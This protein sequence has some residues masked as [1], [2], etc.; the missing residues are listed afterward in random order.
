M[1]AR[2]D[3]VHRDDNAD[4]LVGRTI[5]KRQWVQ[6]IKDIHA[7]LKEKLVRQTDVLRTASEPCPDI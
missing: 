6:R 2:F 4:E 7:L 5:I 1:L 3:V